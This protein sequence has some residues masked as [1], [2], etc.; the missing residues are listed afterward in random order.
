MSLS[1]NGQGIA[2]AFLCI[3]NVPVAVFPP[4]SNELGVVGRTGEILSMAVVE[5]S[6]SLRKVPEL[7][8]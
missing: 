5:W 2:L 6:F 8:K 4:Y 7:G 1:I 3:L